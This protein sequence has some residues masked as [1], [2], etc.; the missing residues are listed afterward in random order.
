MVTFIGI[1]RIRYKFS[2]ELLQEFLIISL[3]WIIYNFQKMM[4]EYQQKINEAQ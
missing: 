3:Y 4:I 1:F 2:R